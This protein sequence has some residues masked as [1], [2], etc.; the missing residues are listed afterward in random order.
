VGVRNNTLQ[1]KV[2]DDL[3]DESLK[4]S[5]QLNLQ[6]GLYANLNRLHFVDFVGCTTEKMTTAKFCSWK[7][8]LVRIEEFVN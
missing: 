1:K 7:K 2:I 8:N 4:N 6:H 5:Q 3:I